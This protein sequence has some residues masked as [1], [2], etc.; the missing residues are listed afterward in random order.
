MWLL[1]CCICDA[2][3]SAF[4]TWT[5]W[6]NI[7]LDPVLV[8]S[9]IDMEFLGF[10]LAKFPS[11]FFIYRVDCWS[12]LLRW[13][14]E[15]GELLLRVVACRRKTLFRGTLQSLVFLLMVQMRRPHSKTLSSDW[16]KGNL[17]RQNCVAFDQV[18]YF[19]F[20]KRFDQIVRGCGYAYPAVT[21]IDCRQ[22]LVAHRD[23]LSANDWMLG[24]QFQVSFLSYP[25][26]TIQILTK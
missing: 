22:A 18:V 23:L 13:T 2:L 11:V 17:W 26:P 21:V 6:L 7:V 4:R 15:L 5:C 8:W 1:I 20:E 16:V 25:S 3:T 24:L 12:C 9:L 14:N 19:F 10:L